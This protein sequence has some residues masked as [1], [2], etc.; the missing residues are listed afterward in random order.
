MDNRILLKLSFIISLI[1]LFSL[2]FLSELLEPK[3]I[4][5]S[6]LKTDYKDYS[7]KEINVIGVASEIKNYSHGDI[8]FKI[9]N[10][11]ESI[12]IAGSFLD[13]ALEQNKTYE[14]TGILQEYNSILSIEAT[15]I[16]PI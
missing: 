4:E 5:I 11:N 8:S 9:T 10:K 13:L 16:N 7:G 14:I 1:G 15:K 2:I 3:L 12:L 6:D